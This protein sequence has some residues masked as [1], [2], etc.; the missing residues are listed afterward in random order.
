MDEKKEEEQTTT[1][2]GKRNKSETNRLIEDTN[3]ALKGWKKPQHKLKQKG[4]RQKKVI[5]R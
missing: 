5:L 3:L 4:K 2:D 1:N